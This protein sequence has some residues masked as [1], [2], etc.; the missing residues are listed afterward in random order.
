MEEISY[1]NF[2]EP[3]NI[4]VFI[5]KY[6]RIYARFISKGNKSDTTLRIKKE[7][8]IDGKELRNKLKNGIVKM[9]AIMTKNSIEKQRS[10]KAKKF[11]SK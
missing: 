7:K 10:V 5:S 1:F 3:E 8:I 2:E 4:K 9:M 11:D 6:K